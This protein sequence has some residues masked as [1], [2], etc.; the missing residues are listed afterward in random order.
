MNSTRAIEIETQRLQELQKI[1][2]VADTLDIL[3]QEHQEKLKNLE[4]DT[5]SKRETLDKEIANR[6]KE[7]Q[8]EQ[9]DFEE[10]LQAYNESLA[11]QRQQET[12]EYQYKLENTR[13]INNRCLRSEKPCGRKR[14]AR[15]FSS[16]GKRLGCTGKNTHQK[17]TFIRRISTESC[18]LS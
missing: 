6:R 17:S 16:K 1:R 18:S 4:Q 13:K 7:W 12:E 2:V 5:A 11:K 15:K 14:I 3:T 10:A 8:K 9:A